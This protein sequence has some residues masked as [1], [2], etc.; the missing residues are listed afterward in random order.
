MDASSKESPMEMN[1]SSLGVGKNDFDHFKNEIGFDFPVDLK[2]HY[3]EFDGGQPDPANF[4]FQGEYYCLHQFLRMLAS[5][6][7]NI[8]E[9]YKMW[10]LEDKVIQPTDIPFGVDPGGDLFLYSVSD[11]TY[12]QIF[13]CT[14]D[15]AWDENRLMKIADSFAE[16]MDNLVLHPD[17]V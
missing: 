13:F 2:E 9:I 3:R 10:A 6:N 14:Q 5:D 17:D 7:L 11:E 8:V 4:L 12:G 1:N 16:L 15:T